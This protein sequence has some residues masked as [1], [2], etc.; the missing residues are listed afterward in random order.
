MFYRP[1]TETPSTRRR[2]LRARVAHAAAQARA[3]LL[4]EEDSGQPHAPL[5]GT[6]WHPHR[7]PLRAPRRG[8]RPG[9][10]A[11]RPSVCLCPVVARLTVWEDGVERR[12][13]ARPGARLTGLDP[14]EL[15][16]RRRVHA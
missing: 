10:G 1:P 7:S 6:S 11:P 8:R 16:A 14:A 4:P 13:G 9:A 3:F 2:T 15:R 12:G 5:G